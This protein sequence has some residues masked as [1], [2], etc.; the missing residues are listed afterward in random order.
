M[1]LYS[2]F[3]SSAA[4]RV[5]IGLNLKGLDYQIKP[6]H[7]LKDGGQQHQPDYV[8]VNPVQLLPALDDD[9]LI[10]TQSLAILEY[11]DERYPELPLLPKA[12]AERAWARSMAQTVACDI[13]PLNNLRVLQYLKNELHAQEDAR[14]QWYR[15]WVSVGLE[16]LE[17]LVQR[18]GKKDHDFIFGDTPGLAEICLIPQMFNARRFDIDLSI[19]PRL[20]AV[21]EKCLEL[22]AFQEA[23]PDRQPDAA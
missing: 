12:S 8:Q 17:A 23:A 4:Y 16:G 19:F 22:S 15:H 21:E 6:V 5:R 1:I 14:N 20:L 13:H 9:G 7:L 3:R 11:L 2:Y 18:H 10:I